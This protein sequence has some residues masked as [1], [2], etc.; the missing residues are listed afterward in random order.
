MRMHLQPGGRS[1]VT[2]TLGAARRLRLS[3]SSIAVLI[4]AGALK[5]VSIEGRRFIPTAEV[6]RY[7]RANPS[8]RRGGKNA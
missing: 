7:I 6:D 1:D 8:L 3:Q 2:T 5:T 4:K